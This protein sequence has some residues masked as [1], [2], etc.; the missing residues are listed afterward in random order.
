MRLNG[1]LGNLD[2]LLEARLRGD[3]TVKVPIL[4]H[5]ERLKG[6]V[7]QVAPGQ[8]GLGP[9]GLVGVLTWGP[10]AQKIKIKELGIR[11][12]IADRSNS[13][14]EQLRASLSCPSRGDCSSRWR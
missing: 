9:G 5:R 6:E 10:R 1:G 14:S 12:K 13:W 8:V 11:E 2:T 4:E 3:D 7:I